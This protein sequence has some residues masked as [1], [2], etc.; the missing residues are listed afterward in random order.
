MQRSPTSRGRT[1]HVFVLV[2]FAIAQPLF[3]LLGR[4]AE[5]LI[6]HGTT[7][8]D[9]TI[10]T[11][12]LAVVL[13]GA[14]AIASFGIERL[15]GR[16]AAA[17]H[18]IVLALLSAAIALPVAKSAL[19]APASVL[20]FGG[21]GPSSGKPSSRGRLRFPEAVAADTRRV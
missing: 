9:L 13:P 3:D 17:V 6:A 5:F 19:L 20:A 11:L 2:S 21:G 7:Q 18:F 10:L 12:F 1:L 15:A 14:I 16:G 8:T 4:H